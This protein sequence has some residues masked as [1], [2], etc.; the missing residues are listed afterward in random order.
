MVFAI[1][2]AD[3]LP[4]KPHTFITRPVKIQVVT[5]VFD[6]EYPGLVQGD[7]PRGFTLGRKLEFFLSVVRFFGQLSPRGTSA[8]AQLG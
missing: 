5:R 6:R 7:I 2:C 8:R 4:Y 1:F 3:N